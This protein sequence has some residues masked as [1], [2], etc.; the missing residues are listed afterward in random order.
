MPIKRSLL[1]SLSR[2]SQTFNE[3]TVV[4][5]REGEGGSERSRRVGGR[6]RKSEKETSP[7]S[8]HLVACRL[9]GT[10]EE[11]RKREDAE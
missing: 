7:S 5:E 10:K 6:E 2:F 9:E 11:K 4:R 1:L 8:Q 3:E